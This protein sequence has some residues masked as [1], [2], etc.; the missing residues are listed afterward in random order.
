MLICNDMALS[1]GAGRFEITLRLLPLL[2]HAEKQFIELEI[3]LKISRQ[4]V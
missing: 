1:V 2:P 4:Q 3:I